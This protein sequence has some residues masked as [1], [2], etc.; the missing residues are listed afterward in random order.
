MEMDVDENIIEAAELQAAAEMAGE[1]MMEVDASQPEGS[2]L[3]EFKPLSAKDQVRARR[4]GG[5][6]CVCVCVC[7]CVEGGREDER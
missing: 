4:L 1:G 7:V 2:N 5:G 3:P 6:K